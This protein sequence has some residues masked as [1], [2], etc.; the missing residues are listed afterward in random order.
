MLLR[1]AVLAR[2]Q[3]SELRRRRAAS[4]AFKPVALVHSRPQCGVMFLQVAG[5][6]QRRVA[7]RAPQR[8]RP[9]VARVA[10]QRARVPLRQGVGAVHVTVAGEAEPGRVRATVHSR[11]AL[12][13]KFTCRLHLLQFQSSNSQLCAGVPIVGVNG[14]GE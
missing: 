3:S 2:P 6:T 8:R 10:Q 7:R 5:L 11:A 4:K 1:V 14:M 13:A 9:R 12:A